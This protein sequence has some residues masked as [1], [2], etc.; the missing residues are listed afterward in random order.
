MGQS[1]A[2]ASGP[3]PDGAHLGSLAPRLC[4]RGPHG[5]HSNG[6]SVFNRR[7]QECNDPNLWL[8]RAAISDHCRR[9]CRLLDF[10]NRYFTRPA[11]MQRAGQAIYT[12]T[13]RRHS[14]LPAWRGEVFL[15]SCMTRN[16][17][18]KLREALK[19]DQIVPY[20]QP[21]VDPRS[22]QLVA[23]RCSRDGRIPPRGSFCRT[24]SSR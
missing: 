3:W 6:G 17:R 20:F 9:R 22:G 21:L 23:S 4:P 18:E 8:P 15:R 13:C 19:N 24:R 2:R 5:G 10:I 14:E 12:V 11:P 1:L 7:G 16:L